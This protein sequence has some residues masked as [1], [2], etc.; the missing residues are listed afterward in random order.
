M[1]ITTA[2]EIYTHVHKRFR[3]VERLGEAGNTDDYNE[4]RR[5][6]LLWMLYLLEDEFG[7][8]PVE[9]GPEAD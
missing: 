4:G 5:D 6:D 9:K 1:S 3:E 7:V 8:M 2:T